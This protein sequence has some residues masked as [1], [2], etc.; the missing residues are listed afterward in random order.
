MVV[1]SVVEDIDVLRELSTGKVNLAEIGRKYGISRQAVLKHVKRLVKR[2]LVVKS[3][4]GRYV[5]TDR[6]RALLEYAPRTRV[7]DL[8][9]IIELL[10]SGID[11]FLST[12]GGST[13]GGIGSY[14]V[15]YALHSF[16]VVGIVAAARASL[17]INEVNVENKLEALWRDWLKPVLG[18]LVAVM[19]ASGVAEWEVIEA[20]FNTMKNQGLV[21]ASILDKH[22]TSSRGL[23]GVDSSKP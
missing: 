21:Y 7:E 23:E 3:P 16:I 8:D 2:G 11:R 1:Y 18:K 19:L 12:K 6:G 10:D 9:R 17:E 5:L 13:S 22:F 14:F 4:E 15:L 20:L